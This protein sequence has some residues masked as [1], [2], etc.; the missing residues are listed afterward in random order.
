MTIAITKV[1]FGLVHNIRLDLSVLLIGSTS[2]DN[3]Y[4]LRRGFQLTY[5]FGENSENRVFF[6]FFL[7]VDQALSQSVDD[8]SPD[9]S[10]H[11]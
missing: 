4:S 7:N 11:A 6:P 2:S 9:K 5:L 3:G 8:V 10:E 1:N